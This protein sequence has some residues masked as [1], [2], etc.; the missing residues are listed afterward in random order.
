MSFGVR[1]MRIE[2]L[3]YLRIVLNTVKK[4]S[5][6]RLFCS[7]FKQKGRSDK[8]FIFYYV[9]RYKTVKVCRLLQF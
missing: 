8:S 7:F 3:S 9:F 4:S 2:K 1:L 6:T 5:K